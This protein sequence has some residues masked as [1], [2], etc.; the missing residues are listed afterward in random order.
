MFARMII[1]LF[2]LM[3]GIAASAEEQNCTPLGWDRFLLPGPQE[4]EVREDIEPEDG[5]L[6]RVLEFGELKGDYAKVF[7]F[8]RF[9]GRCISRAMSLGSY[10]ATNA[11]SEP[12]T[13][14]YHLDL[15]E[16][17]QHATLGFYNGVPTYEFLLSK[18][19][20]HML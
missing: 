13:R 1:V 19:V 16:P 9:D 2:A 8:L 15:Y 5:V 10:A 18:L 4:F 12:G 11:L 17:G 7:L 6:I 20:E 14:T 3:M